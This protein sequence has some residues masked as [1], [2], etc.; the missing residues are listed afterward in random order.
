MEIPTCRST[1]EYYPLK[2]DETNMIQ[3][4]QSIWREAIGRSDR[5]GGNDK[6]EEEEVCSIV[7]FQH[8]VNDFLQKGDPLI[9]A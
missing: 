4:F 3:D 5:A 8:A 7:D 6:E 1:D 2:L 9:S